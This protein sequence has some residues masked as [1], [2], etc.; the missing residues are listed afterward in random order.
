MRDDTRAGIAGIA[1]FGLS[2][3]FAIAGSLLIAPWVALLALVALPVDPAFWRM[4]RVPWG[5]L[6]GGAFLAW[7]ALSALWSPYEGTGQIWR[8]CL[9]IPLYV[10]FV[11]R[12]GQLGEAW[13]HRVEAAMIFLVTGLGLFL[14]AEALFDGVATRGFKLV[15]EGYAVSEAAADV[16]TFVNRNLG[17]AAVPL[18]LLSVPAGLVAWREG[19]P[20]I[21][22][23][24]VALAAIAAFSFDTHVNAA[25]FMLAFVAAGLAVFWPRT[26]ITLVCGI[27][28]GILI[29][30]PLALPELIAALPQGFKDALPLS[31]IWRLEIW[32]FAGELIRE[33]PW[34][35]YGLDASRPLNR[36]LALQGFTV[37]ALPLHPHNATLH[38]WL[39]TGAVGAVLLALAL[40]AMGGRIAAAEQLSRLQAVGAVWI[41]VVYVSLIVFSY[42]VWQ[43][44][45]QGTVALAATSVFFLG[46]K[47]RKSQT[48]RV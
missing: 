8:T 36:E 10:L 3:L 17:H 34:F 31:W 5:L 29:V 32:S 23:A 28:A 39:E 33:R 40:V 45:H 13:Q 24:I 15:E 11:A 30:M 47:K 43:E 26:M 18:L 37:E 6:A 48:S 22:I 35:G 27:T 44:W 16:Q 12:I 9:G 38:I 21:G 42:G 19:G 7:V 25:A 46:A 1:G 14:F 41:F 2:F 20:L 4:R